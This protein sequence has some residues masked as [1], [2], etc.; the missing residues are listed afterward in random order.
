M[1]FSVSTILGSL[2]TVSKHTYRSCKVF[3]FFYLKVIKNHISANELCVVK[4][5]FWDR[6]VFGSVKKETTRLVPRLIRFSRISCHHNNQQLS[7]TIPNKETSIQCNCI[8]L[9]IGK[10]KIS[11]L[12]FP[13]SKQGLAK[14]KISLRGLYF[15]HD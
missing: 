6:N 2:C 12:L 4:N 13:S 11:N 15:L 10:K 1:F 7:L 9:L 8:C 5:V 3:Q 14:Y